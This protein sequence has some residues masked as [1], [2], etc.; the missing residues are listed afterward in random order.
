MTTNLIIKAE[1][2]LI[3]ALSVGASRLNKLL[4]P[5]YSR[6]L[7]TTV[8][9]GNLIRMEVDKRG[10]RRYKRRYP[11][12]KYPPPPISEAKVKDAFNELIPDFT[13]T[14]VKDCGSYIMIFLI[15]GKLYV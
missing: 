3:D 12:P 13:V 15:G 14:A 10:F 2:A 7:R 4:C 9:D 8:V 1:M 6:E 5:Q 11:W